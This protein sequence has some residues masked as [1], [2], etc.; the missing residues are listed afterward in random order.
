MTDHGRSLT[1]APEEGAIPPASSESGAQECH[2]AGVDEVPRL[3]CGPLAA[4]KWRQK[5]KLKTTAVALVLCLNIGVAA[6]L[7]CH[8]AQG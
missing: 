6:H 8:L 7:P 2:D 3:G 4:L 5:E 1:T